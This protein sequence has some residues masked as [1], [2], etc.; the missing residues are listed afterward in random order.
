M[1]NLDAISVYAQAMGINLTPLRET[2]SAIGDALPEADQL[3]VSE[4]WPQFSQF[5]RTE[6]GR[7]AIQMLVSEWRESK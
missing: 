7:E 1:Q 5:L 3:F 6:R 2:M 4:H